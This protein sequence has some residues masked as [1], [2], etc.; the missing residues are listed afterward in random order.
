[1]SPE[2]AVPLLSG[3]SVLWQGKP[4]PRKFFMLADWFFVPF[5][6]FVLAMTISITVAVAASSAPTLILVFAA[7]FLAIFAY[8]SVGRLFLKVFRKTRTS[9]IVTDRR[10]IIRTPWSI[11]EVRLHTA[12]IELVTAGN[13]R[14]LTAIFSDPTLG[15]GGWAPLSQRWVSEQ[16][17]NSGM[18]MFHGGHSPAFY[19]VADVSGLR[20]ALE[21]FLGKPQTYQGPPPYGT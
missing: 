3:E 5:Y 10:A 15:Q 21:P 7:I 14:H 13:G 6:G 17:R 2:S 18:E 12:G 16:F 4:D 1:M 19:D 9:Y 8:L 20:A 11:R